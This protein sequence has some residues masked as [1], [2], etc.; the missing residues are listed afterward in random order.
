MIYLRSVK[1]FRFNGLLTIRML[2]IN[3]AISKTETWKE[4]SDDHKILCMSSDIYTYIKNEVSLE[5]NTY[6]LVKTEPQSVRINP[7]AFFKHRC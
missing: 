4:R 6:V 5:F 2:E 3:C 1:D 7:N